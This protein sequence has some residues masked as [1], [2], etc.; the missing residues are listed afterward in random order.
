MCG[1]CYNYF[2]IFSLFRNIPLILNWKI[3]KTEKNEFCIQ[4]ENHNFVFFYEQNFLFFLF[5]DSG[6]WIL[7]GC[8]FFPQIDWIIDWFIGF[9]TRKNLNFFISF[10]C[11]HHITIVKIVYFI[12]CFLSMLLFFLVCLV[13]F[14]IIQMFNVYSVCVA[15][16][17]WINQ[18][19][20]KKRKSNSSK[21]KREKNWW[22]WKWNR[23]NRANLHQI[24]WILVFFLLFWLIS[25]AMCSCFW[26]WQCVC[27]VCVW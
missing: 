10:F 18:R 26:Y 2:G 27:V 20:K 15:F 12:C 11:H 21:T 16:S 19:K 1:C 24:L 4:H 22:W 17:N 14:V 23:T 3:I 13:S 5:L 6:F 8:F 25:I 7:A 9:L